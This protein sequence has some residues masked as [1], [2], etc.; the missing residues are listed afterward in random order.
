[1]HSFFTELMVPVTVNE[2]DS[3]II[4]QLYEKMPFFSPCFFILIMGTIIISASLLSFLS[5]FLLLSQIQ[6][7]LQNLG[8]NLQNKS[9]DIEVLAV[10]H[11]FVYPFILLNPLPPFFSALPPYLLNSCVKSQSEERPFD[12]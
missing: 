12:S 4:K 3:L 2:S 8:S 9:N 1:M 7:R 11:L 10:S 5:L 6:T